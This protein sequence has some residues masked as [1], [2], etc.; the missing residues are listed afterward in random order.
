MAIRH[1]FGSSRLQLVVNIIAVKTHSTRITISIK[2][3]F[4]CRYSDCLRAGRPRSLSWSSGRVKNFHF[5]IASLPPLDSDQPPTQT[6]PGVKRPRREAD[7]AEV[8]KTW[9]YTS[10]PHTTSPLPFAKAAFAETVANVRWRTIAMPRG[11]AASRI[12]LYPT[13]AFHSVSRIR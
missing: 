13:F 6:I 7:H 4:I 12:S 2:V 9:I 5:S 1:G 10:T 3:I 8:K 11:Y